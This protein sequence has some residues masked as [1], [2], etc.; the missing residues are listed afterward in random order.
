MNTKNSIK[1]FLI[2]SLLILGL[3]A[4]GQKGKQEQGR[5]YEIFYVN[6]EE[7][8]IFAGE[9]RTETTDHDALL[10]ELIEQ[11]GTVPEKLEYKV[12]LSGSL[13]LLGYSVTEDQL[14]LNFD[15]GYL[16]QSV[17]TEVLVRAAIVRTLTQIDGIRYI[18]FQI[19]TEPLKDASG[20]VIGVMTA[21]MF[22]DNAGN[23]INTYEKAKLTLYLAN[24]TGDRLEKV[25][26]TV[27][28]S[29]NISMEKLV[30]EQLI[31]GPQEGD[32]VYPVMNP[33]TRIVSVNTKDGICYVNLDNTFLT[34]I[35]NVN[36]E[37][38][39]YALTNSLV[40][41]PN[42]NKVQISINGD[43]NVSY[44]ENISLST[45]FERNLELV[46]Q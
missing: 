44:K 31:A 4:C 2:L 27:I 35:Y 32:K 8:A 11:L 7:T 5:L 21:D 28:Y 39:I 43:T 29:S 3:C 33:D 12:P 36:S 13:K 24:E 38:T 15:E 34:Q 41:L 23:E 40:E 30:V 25:T 22:V 10:R 46:D 19:K 26:R 14:T 16:T 17:T 1:L 9:Y 45:V 37:V 20:N 18:S 6:H 42:V